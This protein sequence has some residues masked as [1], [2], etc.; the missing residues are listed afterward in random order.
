M[1]QE[2]LRRMLESVRAGELEVTAAVERLRL[3]PFED[4]GFAKVD[5]HRA[6]RHGMPEVV[7]GKGKTPEMI[8]EIC[9]TLLKRGSNVLATRVAPEAAELMKAIAPDLEY[10]PNSSAMRIWRDRAP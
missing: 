8:V 6:L 7:F 3:L 10:F 1:D 2:Q 9:S 5:H 4:I